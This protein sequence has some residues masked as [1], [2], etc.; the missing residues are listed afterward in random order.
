MTAREIIHFFRMIL[1]ITGMFQKDL[2]KILGVS[3]RYMKRLM[4]GYDQPSDQLLERIG[5]IPVK[6]YQFD[7]DSH[8]FQ[9]FLD[10]MGADDKKIKKIALKMG[11]PK[12]KKLLN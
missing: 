1:R 5:I 12:K 2:A 11:E 8:N 9:N 4:A 10:Q 6:T 3:D 7:F